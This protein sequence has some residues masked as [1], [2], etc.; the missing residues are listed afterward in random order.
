ML[1]SA[2]AYIYR[3]VVNVQSIPSALVCESRSFLYHNQDK[4]GFEGFVGFEKEKVTEF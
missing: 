3:S 4:Y 2:G 1:V